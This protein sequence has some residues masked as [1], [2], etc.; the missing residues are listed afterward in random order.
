MMDRQEK[1][2][3]GSSG[4]LLIRFNNGQQKYVIFFFFFKQSLLPPGA[5]DSDHEVRVSTRA[6]LS[7]HSTYRYNIAD[8]TPERAERLQKTAKA[9][10]ISD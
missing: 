5:V 4:W 10:S 7:Q 6:T 1:R 8:E 2:V 9:R 3:P